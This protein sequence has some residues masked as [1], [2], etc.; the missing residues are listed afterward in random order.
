MSAAASAGSMFHPHIK[1]LIA[2]AR[3]RVW[4]SVWAG[5]RR[6]TGRP[7]RTLARRLGRSAAAPGRWPRV[8]P[9]GAW[10]SQTR[11][12][13][14]RSSRGGWRGVRRACRTLVLLGRRSP[15]HR[16]AISAEAGRLGLST[17]CGAHPVGSEPL[18]VSCS[19]LAATGSFAAGEPEEV[20]R[21]VQREGL[22][23]VDLARYRTSG[24]RPHHRVA[25]PDPQSQPGRGGYS[26]SGN[27]YD[28][29]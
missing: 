19:G 18:R 6:A 11:S 14:R 25:A 12:G 16:G 23:C 1:R 28:R 17:K 10:P 8:S 2:F 27:R 7:R 20:D 3:T 13:C 29:C 4:D 26:E 21:Q 9:G 22:L 5:Q 15:G 24:A